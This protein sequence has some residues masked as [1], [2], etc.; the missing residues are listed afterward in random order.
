MARNRGRPKRKRETKHETVKAAANKQGI[1]A[2]A[3][4]ATT[5][6][7]TREN[8][9][10]K[11]VAATATVA[12]GTNSNNKNKTDGK[13]PIDPN[14]TDETN[15]PVGIGEALPVV[16]K[17]SPVEKTRATKKTAALQP[18]A[19]ANNNNN[20]SNKKA[21][22]QSNGATSSAVP[23]RS[24]ETR[25][26]V[27]L[28]PDQ[29]S[30]QEEANIIKV[31]MNAAGREELNCKEPLIM[32]IA[33]GAKDWQWKLDPD[34]V[35]FVLFA[36][37][38]K[39]SKTSFSHLSACLVGFCQRVGI[40][41][42]KLRQSD[43]SQHAQMLRNMLSS[44]AICI[45]FDKSICSLL[46]LLDS[47]RR[48]MALVASIAARRPSQLTVNDA[49]KDALCSWED[50]KMLVK[51]MGPRI[52]L[53]RGNAL[54]QEE[55]ARAFRL[56]DAKKSLFVIL[57]AAVW[58]YNIECTIQLIERGL[59]Q[60]I[61]VVLVPTMTLGGSAKFAAIFCLENEPARLTEEE[62]H[63]VKDLSHRMLD[64]QRH[65]CNNRRCHAKV[66]RKKRPGAGAQ[67]KSDGACNDLDESTDELPFDNTTSN[68]VASSN[69]TEETVSVTWATTVNMIE[70]DNRPMKDAS[71][72]P[73]SDS[74]PVAAPVDES[75]EASDRELI[76]L[77]ETVSVVESSLNLLVARF[78]ETKASLASEESNL[79][80]LYQKAKSL[81]SR[82]QQLRM[83]QARQVV[84]HR[85]LKESL[86]RSRGQLERLTATE[87]VLTTDE[88]TELAAIGGVGCFSS[89][90]GHSESPPA[91]VDGFHSTASS[92]IETN[93]SL[94]E[95]RAPNRADR[96]QSQSDLKRNETV[97][98]LALEYIPSLIKFGVQIKPCEIHNIPTIKRLRMFWSSGEGQGITMAGFFPSLDSKRLL[99]A[100]MD[101]SVRETLALDALDS[102]GAHR[103]QSMWN[104]LLDARLMADVDAINFDAPVPQPRQKDSPE[105]EGLSIGAALL[106]ATAKLDVKVASARPIAGIDPNVPLC[107]YE[108]SGLCLDPYC[109]YQHL[110]KRSLFGNVL[111]REY[112]PL[113]PLSLAAEQARRLEA[114]TKEAPKMVK[115]DPPKNMLAFDSKDSKNGSSK[116][117]EV[118]VTTIDPL[119]PVS[120]NNDFIALGEASIGSEQVPDENTAVEVKPLVWWLSEHSASLLPQSPAYLSLSTIL[121][122]LGC[123]FTRD[124]KEVNIMPQYIPKT[125]ADACRTAGRVVDCIRFA[126]HAGRFDLSLALEALFQQLTDLWKCSVFKR[127]IRKGM[128][129][130]KKGGDNTFVYNCV[131]SNPLGANKDV[132][133]KKRH[134]VRRNSFVVAFEAQLMTA[135]VSVFLEQF[136]TF[137]DQICDESNEAG[138]HVTLALFEQAFSPSSRELRLGKVNI[139]DPRSKVFH[140][141]YCEV[142][143]RSEVEG[144]TESAESLMHRSVIHRLLE[145]ICRGCSLKTAASEISSI[146]SLIDDVVQPSWLACKEWLRN[147]TVE[148]RTSSLLLKT[149]LLMG[150]IL[151][152]ALEKAAGL[153]PSD[154][155]VAELK[156]EL[157]ELYSTIDRI[158][159]ALRRETRLLPWVDLILS[160]LFAANVS[161]A[162]TIQLYE[163]AQNRLESLVYRGVD[164]ADDA[165]SALLDVHFASFSDLLWSQLIQL[166]SS[167]PVFSR[168]DGE[169]TVNNRPSVVGWKLSADTNKSHEKL[170]ARIIG[171]GLCLHYVCL[172]ND[173]NVLRALNEDGGLAHS[174]DSDLLQTCAAMVESVSTGSHR[175]DL[176]VI[177][178]RKRM[179]L[180][181][182]HGQPSLVRSAFPRSLLLAGSR[183]AT[184][185]LNGCGLE[186]LP[187]HFGTYFPNLSVSRIAHSCL[188]AYNNL[189]S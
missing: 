172:D 143:G 159:S 62:A 140:V 110:E 9:Q 55:F 98:S 188:Y 104:T 84:L 33:S 127:I 109:S 14:P 82:E 52:R 158:L 65:N 187:H 92:I 164:S 175:T 133:S 141:E 77:E 38:S 64:L 42:L 131:S 57:P 112:I 177:L 31:A 49:W 174:T 173:W 145:D 183:F 5:R 108:L 160:P 150:Y 23:T 169:T 130:V 135:L 124:V 138:W 91:S 162:C 17:S 28:T 29:V 105:V 78:K 171:K 56:I 50:R 117:G 85:E 180:L 165:T 71:A 13:S 100:V 72:K 39:N 139:A 67:S 60:G 36:A 120:N 121:E 18:E 134:S 6:K 189:I 26:D 146:R 182:A 66:H 132:A 149:I 48:P 83:T 126:I 103:R 81:Q 167:L 45:C 43:G 74:L 90:S 166:R 2:T 115:L 27:I 24:D 116:V 10:V 53:L 142:K 76:L 32:C 155:L 106:E 95:I 21:K 68:A 3:T 168:S 94:G 123:Q 75:F 20:N 59:K 44:G 16:G 41:C 79:E 157:T 1:V 87:S 63:F 118:P 102:T 25:Q 151:L 58:L 181:A 170:A 119:T 125:T 8:M 113:P 129:I 137:Q 35:S 61:P 37:T 156:A 179:S 22:N 154:D 51:T 40:P 111:P 80:K 46:N 70:K 153:I 114:D 88:I 122:V 47:E 15:V 163:K 97:S 128:K 93:A 184:L 176:V 73:E 4:T 12:N 148:E 69:I 101:I 19:R 96:S 54:I 178:S 152:G 89:E 144:E 30:S 161:L 185:Q 86:L 7:R 136:C 147:H 11:T 107:P 99:K 34:R 186:C